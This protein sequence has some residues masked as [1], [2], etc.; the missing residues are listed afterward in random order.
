MKLALSTILTTGLLVTLA[1][2]QEEATKK[3]LE[4]IQGTW[5]LVSREKDGKAD[6]A[7]TIKDFLMINEGNKFTFKGTSGAGATKGTFTLDATKKPKAMDRTPGDGP[8][9]GKTLLGIYSLEGDTLKI[10]VSLAG[11]ERPGEFATAPKSGLLLSVFK[12]EK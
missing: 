8:Q 11:K 5:R 4:Q 3:D 1:G 7:D 12:R 6:A 9:K 10:C 2:A